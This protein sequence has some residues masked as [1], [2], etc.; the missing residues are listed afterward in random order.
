MTVSKHLLPSFYEIRNSDFTKQSFC[1][2]V[3]L[4]YFLNTLALLCFGPN[5]FLKLC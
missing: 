3:V 1:A 2:F 4:I 5:F